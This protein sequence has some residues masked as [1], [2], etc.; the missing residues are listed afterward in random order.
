MTR[1]AA[2]PEA[3]PAATAAA[4]AA[5]AAVPR[6]VL[7]GLV[8]LTV[9]PRAA[10]AVRLGGVCR[11]AH[12]YQVLG[13]RLRNGDLD[14]AFAYAGLNLFTLICAATGAAGEWLGV[15][16]IAAALAWGV[17]AAGLTA[18]PLFDWVRRQFGAA[19]AVA[20]G[21]AFAVHPTLIEVG[22]EPIRDGTFWLCLVTALAALHRA[23]DPDGADASPLSSPFSPRRRLGWFLAGGLAAAAAALTRTEGWLLLAP[24]VGWTALA[25]WRRP[26][27]RAGLLGGAAAALAVGPAALLAVN[28]TVLHGHP[29]W[30]WGRVGLLAEAAGWAAEAVGFEPGSVPGAAVAVDPAGEALAAAAPPAAADSLWRAYLDGLLGAFKPALLVLVALGGLLNARRLRAPDALPLWAM[31][32]ALLV[33]VGLRLHHHGHFN[34][35]YFLPAAVLSLPTAGLALAAAW[36]AVALVAGTRVRS[37]APGRRLPAPAAAWVAAA[38]IGGAHVADGLQAAHPRRTLERAAAGL[39]RDRIPARPVGTKAD[40]GGADPGPDVWGFGLAANLAEAVGG[41][42]RTVYSDDG[43]GA[44]AEAAALRPDLILLPR[45]AG[46]RTDYE[47]ARALWTAAGYRPLDPPRMPGDEAVWDRFVALV[48]DPAAPG[49]PG[50]GGPAIGS[51]TGSRMATAPKNGVIR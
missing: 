3:G 46:C 13:S 19:A 15:S 51:A 48:P 43:P 27:D 44:T 36:R 18:V 32:T 29:R 8:A 28:L 49:G 33:G 16:P 5:V 17:V 31:S 30:E 42:V 6:W 41:R 50:A 25:A 37:G 47:P 35:R 12:F 38:L 45:D 14:G 11:D 10:L 2:P 34:G 7:P 39:L 40:R 4:P 26:A 20:A 23:A 22:V 1:P 21:A 24:L 9:V